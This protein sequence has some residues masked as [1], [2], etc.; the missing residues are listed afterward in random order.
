MDPWTG[1]L[2][3]RRTA[4][5]RLFDFL[6]MLHIMDYDAREDFNHPLLQAAAILGFLVALSGV[7]FWFLTRRPLRRR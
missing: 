4:R 7:V 3:A 2:L 1:E 5:W 6:W